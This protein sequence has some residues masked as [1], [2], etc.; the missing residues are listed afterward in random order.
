MAEKRKKKPQVKDKGELI[1]ESFVRVEFKRSS[2]CLFMYGAKNIAN[3]CLHFFSHRCFL[4]VHVLLS[5]AFD[6]EA[7]FLTVI[8][9]LD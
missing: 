3:M 6:Y 1:S 8:M 4:F 5:P 9:P 2:F 7:L